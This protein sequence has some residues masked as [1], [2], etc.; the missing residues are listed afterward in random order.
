MNPLRVFTLSS[1][2][3][4]ASSQV[5]PLLRCD[6][7]EIPISTRNAPALL[8]D[9][10]ALPSYTTPTRAL[11]IS[12][13]LRA[14]RVTAPL[15]YREHDNSTPRLTPSDVLATGAKVQCQAGTGQL[16]KARKLSATSTTHHSLIN[17]KCSSQLLRTSAVSDRRTDMY[18]ITSNLH[19]LHANC[20]I[21]TN[22][23][24]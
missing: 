8:S 21:S 7:S 15:A 20:I 17:R 11:S 2:L 19:G 12:A 18:I 13:S 10:Q 3:L 4:H 1:T 23:T 14:A 24:T 16:L 6:T 5:T 22:P 9:M